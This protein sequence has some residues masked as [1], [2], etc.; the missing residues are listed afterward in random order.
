MIARCHVL[1]H[2]APAALTV[3][4]IIGAL[5]ALLEMCIR[6]RAYHG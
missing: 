4:A 3:V 5:T 2:Q 1:F 6:D